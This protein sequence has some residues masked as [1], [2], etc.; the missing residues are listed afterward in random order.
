MREIDKALADILEIRSQI[1]AG[2]AFRG[3][4]PVAI[5]ITGLVGLVFAAAQSLWPIAP[6]P[7][8]FIG[9]WMAAAAVCGTVIRLEMQGRTRRLHSGLADAMI[10]QAIEQFLPAVAAC[11]CLPVLLLRFVPEATWMVPGMWQVFASLGIFASLRSLPRP[12]RLVGAWYFVT[13]FACLLAASQTHALSP[14]M[15]GLPFFGGQMMMA[16]I[17]YYSVGDSDAED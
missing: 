9:E 12:I 13:G 1:A 17:L 8:S 15:M 4:G 14:W 3:Y 16:A 2:T 7:T 10:H 11:F 5:G 6:T